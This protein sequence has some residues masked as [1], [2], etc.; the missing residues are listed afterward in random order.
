MK[1]PDNQPTLYHPAAALVV[2]SA[3]QGHAA[4]YIEYYDMDRQGC[5]INPRPFTIRQA[6]G[7]AQALSATK[8]AKPFL[9]PSGIIPSKVLHIDPSGN[10]RVVWHTKAHTRKL[11]FTDEL[12][13]LPETL[14]LPTLV[15]VAD[16]KRLSVFAL[17]AK[18]RPCLSTALFHAPFFNL[19]RNGNVCMGTVNISISASASLEEFIAAWEGYF[20]GSYFSHLIDGHNP[21]EG[22]LISLYKS[23]EALNAFPCDTL[24]ANGLT[25]KDML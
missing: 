6:H 9:K 14:P 3:E 16:K 21:I 8:G 11:H 15:W 17:K 2:F 1:T 4:P 13:P 24:I 7:L 25:L 12:L 23:L 19:Y 22:N 10:A 20:F 18:G 5:P